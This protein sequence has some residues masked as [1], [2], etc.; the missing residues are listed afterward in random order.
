MNPRQVG[1]FMRRFSRWGINI[2]AVFMVA[3]GVHLAFSGEDRDDSLIGAAN[4]ILGASLL[5]LVDDEPV[6]Q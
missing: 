5:S 4:I 3:G 2:L 1:L 6:S